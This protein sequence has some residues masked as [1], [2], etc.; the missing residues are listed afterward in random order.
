MNPAVLQK[1]FLLKP[2]DAFTP[3]R[4]EKAQDEL[5]QMRVFK[6]LDFSTRSA[7]DGKTDI[8]ISA[9]D[10]YY[11]FPMA[12]VTGG[13][14]SAA[15]LSLAGGNLFKQGENTFAFIGASDDGFAASLGF[16]TPQDAFAVSFNKL[17]FNQRFY[18]NYWS[19]TFGVFSTTD[20]EDEY[21][22]ELLDQVHTKTET[23][24]VTYSRRFSRTVR[25]FIRPQYA[26]YSYAHHKFDSGNHSQITAG[27]RWTDDIRQGANMGA[28]SGYGLTDKQKTLRN[29][30]RT[31]SG[32]AL[33]A[34]YTAGGA[35]TGADY[36]VSKLALEAAWVLELKNRHMLVLQAKA[37]DAFNA[38]FSD[39]PLSSELLSIGRYDRQIRGTRGAGAGATFIYYL[40]RNQ[41]GLLSIAPFYE[42]AYMRAGG[43]Y[44]PQSGAGATLAYKLWRFPLPVGI[45]YTRGLEDGNNLVG[46]VIGGSF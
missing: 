26:R 39:Q 1:R 40:L 6:K 22:N 2:G 8:R 11:L 42:I 21:Q 18:R 46:F 29:L 7:P 45:N 24:S 10:G 41:T 23:F 20:D 30:P 35:W 43:S 16:S 13:S 31:R 3:E 38:S 44:H 17:N 32:Y 37:Q 34:D 33:G 19:N 5:H 25:A 15:G 12:F 36:N 14:K 9:E 28:L 27:L 4:Y